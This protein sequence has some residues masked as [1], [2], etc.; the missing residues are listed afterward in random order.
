VRQPNAYPIYDAGYRERLLTIRQHLCGISNLQTIGRSGLF[1]Y[2]NMDHSMQA[3]FLAAKNI[4]KSVH[5]LWR[6]EEESYLEE[7]DRKELNLLTDKIMATTFTRMDPVSFALA[8]GSVA[9]FWTFVATI[10]LVVKG[11]EVVGPHLQLLSQVF[12]GYTVTNRGAFLAL[13]YSFFWGFL[14]GWLFSYL[15][16][17]ILIFTI[18]RARKKAERVTFADFFDNL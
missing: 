2:N 11:G 5:D 1:R 13:G 8:V 15:R 17:I 14:V 16:N 3:G 10:F 6:M 18:Y 9:G 7:H 4:K 12:A